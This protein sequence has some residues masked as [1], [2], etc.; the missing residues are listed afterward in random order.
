MTWDTLLVANRG[1]IACRVIRAARSLGLRT[2]A[3]YSEVD[4]EAPHVTLADEAV[5]LGPAEASQSYLNLDLIMDAARLTGAGAIHPGYGFFSENPALPERCHQ[6]GITWVGPPPE[7]IRLMG[8][9]RAARV[10]VSARGVPCVP[11]YDGEDQSDERLLV[12]A[13]RIGF[14][15]MV[16]ASMGGG[17]KGMRLVHQL[18]EVS[19]ALE[20]ARRE[21]SAA[22]GDGSLILERAVLNPKHI[23]IQVFADQFGTVVH[24]GERECSLQRRHQKVVEEAPS[25]ALSAEL[26]AEMGAAA[27][28]VAR[29]VQYEGAG[30]VEF[31]LDESGQYYFLEMNTRIQVEHPV[32]EEVYGVDLVA[33]QLRV[34]R[35]EALP[36]RQAE[37]TDRLSGHAIE[38]RLYAE[39]PAQDFLPQAGPIRLWRMPKGPGIRVDSGVGTEV[40][41]AYDPMLAKVIA[42]GETREIA[43]ARLIR[44]LDDLVLFGPTHNLAFLRQLLSAPEFIEGR[45]HTRTIDDGLKASPR[46]APT[47]LFQGLAAIL[48]ST[49]QPTID[50]WGSSVRSTWPVYLELDVEG[51][52]LSSSEDEQA[53]GELKRRARTQSWRVSQLGPRS[54]SV[55]LKSDPLK[56]IA[57]SEQALTFEID[58]VI[59]LANG[60]VQFTVAG[61]RH[62]V[63]ALFTA[64]DGEGNLLELKSEEGHTLR[65]TD[66]TYVIDPLDGQGSSDDRIKAPMSGKVIAVRCEEGQAVQSGDVLLIIEAMKLEHQI[67]APADGVVKELSTV[68]GDQV[69]SKQQL[70]QLEL[71]P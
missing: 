3:V 21:A 70:I 10:A 7:A 12:E 50:G 67:L 2:V 23:E 65:F 32:T 16:K 30:T 14:P 37:L 26:R 48:V 69:S 39:D 68:V 44:A 55:E 58:D 5:C 19:S 49:V 66:V 40:S 11:G 61:R 35:G 54:Y 43:R 41:P 24:L 71:A 28:E 63:D 60:R 42:Y 53:Q 25:P 9:K 51:F 4:R 33:W 47:D 20:T 27:V 45:A 17:G 59:N 18:S 29:S 8:D 52:E 36:Y 1:E 6:E 56:L 62:R 31:L 38:V 34:A 57:N 64:R 15:L 13:E 46:V 22:F